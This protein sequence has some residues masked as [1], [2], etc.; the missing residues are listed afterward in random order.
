MLSCHCDLM[1]Q[2]PLL[3]PRVLLYHT[4]WRKPSLHWHDKLW[5]CVLQPTLL[6]D[7]QH[8]MKHRL[9]FPWL[10]GKGEGQVQLRI[11]Y[12]PFELLYS[13]PRDASLVGTT[14][15]ISCKQ[16]CLWA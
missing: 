5:E 16:P 10:Q 11:T 13:K 1:R 14:A 6:Q 3:L 9:L 2:H 4:T 7:T 12:F 8:G 15:E